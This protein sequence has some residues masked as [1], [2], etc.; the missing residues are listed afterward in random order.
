MLEDVEAEEVA[1]ERQAFA[2]QSEKLCTLNLEECLGPT[3]FLD[4]APLSVVYSED[5]WALRARERAGLLG[6]WLE[7]ELSNSNIFD[8]IRECDRIQENDPQPSPVLPA[9]RPVL[10]SGS[11]ASTC[12]VGL[13]SCLQERLTRIEQD[14]QQT[15]LR[16]AGC[17]AHSQ[18]K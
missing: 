9:H 1:L 18:A 17:W 4:A 2:E 15:I 3:L 10:A 14:H 5:V 11:R 8:T 7:A 13:E 16:E 12:L 6:T